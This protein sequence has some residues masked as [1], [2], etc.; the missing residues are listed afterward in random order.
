MN[1]DRSKKLILKARQSQL[2]QLNLDLDSVQKTSALLTS[3]MEL[4]QVLEVVVKTVAQTIGADAGALRLIDPDQ[5]ELV[6]KATYGLSRAYINKGPVTAGESLLN[7][8]V[9]EGES[10]VVEDMRTD[11][12]FEKYHDHVMSEGLISCLTIGLRYKDQGIGTLRL[13]SKTAKCFSEADISTVEIV[14]SQSAAAIVNARLYEESLENERM[15]RQ[16][17]L[18]GVVQRHLIPQK[19]P[20]IEGCQLAGLYVPCYDVGGD[21]YDF[22]ETS[23]S[24][25]L[26]NIG[27]IMGKGVPASLVMASLRSS[28]RAYG[29]QFDDPG[30]L[31]ARANQMFCHDAEVGE[32]ATL[33]CARIETKTARFTYCNGGH[34]PPILI[35]EG[36]VIDLK[37]GG[38]VIGLS[39][40]SEYESTTLQLQVDDMILMYTDGLA[41]AFNFQHESFGRERIIQAALDSAQMPAEQAAKNILW[42]MRKFAGLTTRTDDTA[43]IVLK[44]TS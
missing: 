33:F 7:N 2:H 11:S 16:I 26:I 35:R 21:F 17:R 6:L 40:D 5:Q 15:A 12:Q 24:H 37:Q 18:A 9:L 38:T 1:K 27:D 29:E 10:I 39:P 41:D 4:Q 42:L 3:P 43:L 25:L 22:L 34:E 32:F 13:Y 30:Q 8:A 31:M 19:P 28:L 44:K 23:Q 14:A 36:K 20:T